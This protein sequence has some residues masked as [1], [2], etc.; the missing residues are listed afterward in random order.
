VPC[1]KAGANCTTGE[2]GCTCEYIIH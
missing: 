1:Q 2:T